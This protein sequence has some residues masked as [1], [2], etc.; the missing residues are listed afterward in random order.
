MFVSPRTDQRRFYSETGQSGNVKSSCGTDIPDRLALE[1]SSAQA[2]L[3][4]YTQDRTGTG[5]Q[6]RTPGM[7]WGTG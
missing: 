3:S 5:L 7:R 1:F 4:F 2:V 6:S